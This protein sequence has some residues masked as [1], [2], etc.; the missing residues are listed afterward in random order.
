[1]LGICE[2][3]LTKDEK[4]NKKGEILVIGKSIQ[5]IVGKK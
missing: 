3:C 1:V 2:K 4:F 5:S